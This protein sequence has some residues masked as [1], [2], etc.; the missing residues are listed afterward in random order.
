LVLDIAGNL[1]G[2][3]S[4]GGEFKYGTV[5]RLSP[6]GKKTMLHEF[7]GTDG[8]APNGVTADSAGT[9][10]GT[11][12]LGGSANC[13]FGC[14]TVFKVASDGVFATLYR[15]QGHS[16]G[17]GADPVVEPIVDESG[18]LW[19]TTATGGAHDKG[20]IYK[21]APDG[22]ETLLHS[23]GN[24]NGILPGGRLLRDKSG[25]FYGTASFGGAFGQGTIY[26]FKP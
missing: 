11:T 10:Y 3:T 21:I 19:G 1:Y 9:L 6:D 8:M 24:R 4:T 13:P 22:A 12:N 5:F 16:T 7:N 20:T 23:F 15:F 26:E 17:D 14:G 2:T 25:T 18:T